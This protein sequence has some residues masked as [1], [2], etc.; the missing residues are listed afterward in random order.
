VV[1]VL[2]VLV[3]VLGVVLELAVLLLLLPVAVGV[4]V[5]LRRPWTVQVLGPDRSVRHSERV[6][7]WRASGCRIRELAEDVRAG[8][9]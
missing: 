5:A 9:I 1:F 6:V 4:R 7:G 8:R 3:V 2:P